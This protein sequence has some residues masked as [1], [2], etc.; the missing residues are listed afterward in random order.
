MPSVTGT[1]ALQYQQFVDFASADGVK[2]K[3]ILASEK[4]QDG[5]LTIEPA[6]ESITTNTQVPVG[7][8]FAETVAEITI[9]E[10]SISDTMTDTVRIVNYGAALERVLED[11][12][13]ERTTEG[14]TDYRYT[15][16]ES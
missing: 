15:E 8:T 9:P 10:I 13:T 16:Q 2:D 14:G 3:T 7:D 1:S 11:G 4:T 12:T 6:T 5:D